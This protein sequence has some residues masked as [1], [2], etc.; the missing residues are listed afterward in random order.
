MP[1]NPVPAEVNRLGDILAFVAAVRTGSF[2]AAAASLGLSR[3]AIGKSVVRLET[4]LATRLL[5]RTTRRLSLIDEGRCA[6]ERWQKI[7]VELQEVEDSVALRRGQPSGA[8]GAVPRCRRRAYQNAH[9]SV[10][11]FRH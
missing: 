6:Y 9:R 11:R 2:T 7:L 10:C 3:S 8:S 5:H 4:C 1:Q